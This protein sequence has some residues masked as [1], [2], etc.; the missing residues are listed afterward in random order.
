METVKTAKEGLSMIDYGEE[1]QYRNP[2]IHMH[3]HTHMHKSTGFCKWG[4]GQAK[5]YSLPHF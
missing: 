1:E 3:A 5:I 2:H 4:L